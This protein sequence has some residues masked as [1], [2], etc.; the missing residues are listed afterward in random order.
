MWFHNEYILLLYLYG[1]SSPDPHDVMS[2]AVQC[3]D[4]CVMFY[5]SIGDFCSLLGGKSKG[6]CAEQFFV[7]IKLGSDFINGF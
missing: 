5:G 6:A 7:S 4:D 3:V 1:S 2:I